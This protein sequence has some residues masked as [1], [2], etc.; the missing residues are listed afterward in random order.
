[1][2]K[3][4]IN[5]SILCILATTTISC[6]KEPITE[7]SNTPIEVFGENTINLCYTVDGIQHFYPIHNNG[8]WDTF[9]ELVIALA[10][11]GHNVQVMNERSISTDLS[12]KE[13]LVYT[14][15][16]EQEATNW[17]KARLLEGYKVS[18]VFDEETGKY[19]CIAVR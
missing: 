6:Q 1:M 11:D 4:I 10:H 15:Q 3:T 8:E 16:N 19:I 17:M 12:T 13:T 7:Q 2:K 9:W 5:I 18:F 14:T